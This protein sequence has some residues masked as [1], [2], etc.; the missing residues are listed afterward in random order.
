MFSVFLMSGCSSLNTIGGCPDAKIEWIDVLKVNDIKY[1][2]D[3]QGLSEGEI[4]TGKKIGEVQFNLADEGCT[5]HKLKNGDAAYLPVG[6]E[7]YELVG[8]RSDFRVVAENRVFQVSEN[9]KAKTI[10]DL[11]DIKD[12]VEKMSYRSDYDGSHISDFTD[13]ETEEFIEDFLSLE[14]LGYDKVYKKIK[15]T[16]RVFLQMHLKD[17]SSFRIVNWLDE[18]VLSTGAIGT[19]KMKRIVENKVKN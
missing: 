13:E 5:N 14:N 7:I 1:E 3:N 17:G 19:E 16:N 11:L 15:A 10:S 18:N 12:K 6:T 9:K 4:E 2:S 8:Y